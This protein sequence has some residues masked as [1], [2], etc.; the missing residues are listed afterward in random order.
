MHSFRSDDR[1]M[2]RSNVRSK[3]SSNERKSIT[4]FKGAFNTSELAQN[5]T[6]PMR[7]SLKKVGLSNQLDNRDR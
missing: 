1:H 4:D 7:V 6:S 2:R 3:K 5:T